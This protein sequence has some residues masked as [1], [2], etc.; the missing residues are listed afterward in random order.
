M[1]TIRRLTLD[2]AAAVCAIHREIK[3]YQGLPKQSSFYTFPGGWDHHTDLH[4]K[5]FYAETVVDPAYLYLGYFIDDV[6]VSFIKC[7]RWKTDAGNEAVT[8][9]LMIST[10]TIS[11]PK[12]HGGKFWNDT[13]V[14]LINYAVDLFEAQGIHEWYTLRTAA[15]KNWVPITAV[16]GCK[17]GSYSSTMVEDIGFNTS[18]IPQYLKNISNVKF[19]TKQQ[20]WK[21]TKPESK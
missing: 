3:S 7:N 14:E 8:L 10:N 2:D 6:L 15:N 21:L 4:W 19:T 11:L 18:S 17:L 5:P 9:G 20:I 12:T 1:D 16:N 13:I